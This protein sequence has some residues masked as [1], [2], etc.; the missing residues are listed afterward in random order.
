[1]E[2]FFVQ[3]HNSAS[4]TVQRSLNFILR[5]EHLLRLGTIKACCGGKYANLQLCREKSGTSNGTLST[6]SLKVAGAL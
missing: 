6:V 3:G 4:F 1:M 2:R 5:R